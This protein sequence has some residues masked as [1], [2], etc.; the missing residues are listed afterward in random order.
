MEEGS[1]TTAREK[2][3]SPA[4]PEG[5]VGATQTK[6]RRWAVAACMV[7]CFLGW[8]MSTFLMGYVGQR[9]SFRA[10]L[11]YNTL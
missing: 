6:K 9:A 7:V 8:G 11:L 5:T 1:T 3:S 4:P 2:M 10:S